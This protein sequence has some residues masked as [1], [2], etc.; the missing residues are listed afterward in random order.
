M[1]VAVLMAMIILDFPSL[2]VVQALAKPFASIPMDQPDTQYPQKCILSPTLHELYQRARHVRMHE[3]HQAARPL[4][5][6]LLQQNPADLTVATRLAA[7]RSVPQHLQQLFRVGSKS[8]AYGSRNNSSSTPDEKKQQQ[9]ATAL[10]KLLNDSNYNSRSIAVLVLDKQTDETTD[11]DTTNVLYDYCCPIYLTP[12]AAGT[13]SQLPFGIL[14]TTTSTRGGDA[15]NNNHRLSCLVSLFLLGLAVPEQVVRAAFSKRDVQLLFSLG[16][17]H[18]CEHD[19]DL[20]L[21]YVAI[22]PVDLPSSAVDS[23]TTLFV[24]T[25]WHPRVLST[26]EIAAA[27]VRNEAEQAVMYL[28]PDSLSLVQHWT[29]TTLTDA[30]DDKNDDASSSVWLDL[31]TGSGIQALAALHL[32]KCRCA[33]C[34]DTNPRALAFTRFNAQLNGISTN[35]NQIVLVQGD[36]LS[37]QG[38]LFVDSQDMNV[39]DNI[40]YEPLAPLLQRLAPKKYYNVVTA[41]PPFLPVPPDIS[42]SSRH[43]LFST[44]G[45]SGELV[46]AAVLDLSQRVLVPMGFC[47]IVSE[48][49]FTKQTS[50]CEDHADAQGKGD[51][52]TSTESLLLL[53]RL[54][55]Y[56]QKSTTKSGME[57][58][59][60]NSLLLTNEFPV[61]ADIYAWRRADSLEEYKVWRAH[62]SQQTIASCSPG[63]LYIRKGNRTSPTNGCH[64]VRV[65][66]S[67][68]GSI[69][70]PSNR[71]AVEY[72]QRATQGYFSLVGDNNVDEQCN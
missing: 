11:N 24:A 30:C 15:N 42:L 65:P 68:R 48:F 64:H 6:S 40:M 34:V 3:G 36:L 47:A 19:A 4:Y 51:T 59:C 16:I 67:A 69:W 32:N 7:S 12:A 26:T 72:T 55:S 61:S 54:Q 33:V 58:N 66:K 13:M 21:P 22:F 37:G 29:A 57:T 27:T 20:L 70:T 56:W 62:L 43:G 2:Q 1:F 25:D 35:C 49:F 5:Q 46:L 28:G 44:G 18:R 71:Q 38:R 9:A 41:N 45:P 8:C 52:A 23:T 10:R 53:K 17:L 63:L 50:T 31:C 39:I 14:A 60:S